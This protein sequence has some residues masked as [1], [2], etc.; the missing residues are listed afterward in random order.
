M[1]DKPS[2]SWLAAFVPSAARTHPLWPRIEPWLLRLGE[3]FLAQ[4]VQQVLMALGGFLLLRWMPVE[5]YAAFTLAFA[6]QSAMIAFV[7]VGFSGAI[8]PLVGVRVHDPA[9][10]GAYVAGARRLRLQLLPFVLAGGLVAFV[11]LGIRQHLEAAMIVGLFSLVSVTIWCNAISVLHGAPLV[12]RQEL[13]FLQAMQNVMGVVR[14]MIYALGHVTG[15]LGSIFALALNTVLN[16]AQAMAMSRRGRPTFDEPHG[17]SPATAAARREILLF[18]R[19]QVPVLVF[20]ALQG[21]IIVFLISVFG[22]GAALAA[23]G[24]LSRLNLMF[25]VVPYFLGWI[26]LPY[27]SRI[28]RKLVPRRFW[29]LTLAG[30]MVLALVPLTG[31]LWPALFLWLLGPNYTYLRLEV[32]LLL[33]ASA[34]GAGNALIATLSLAR[35]WVFDDAIIWIAGLGIGLQLAAAA[36]LDIGRPAGAIS[37]TIAGNFGIGLAY[38]ALA[39]RGRRRDIQLQERPAQA[40][41]RI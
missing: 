17:D 7:D 36:V 4:G 27:F 5:D 40:A 11:I 39:M 41:G 33:L 12:I 16:G 18:A 19:P 9:V 10:I 30:G 31:F 34:I 15:W 20:N 22:S 1:I 24:A 14:V 38:L 8:V 23:T 35:N 32:G 26:V 29:Q 28:D 25:S 3:F 21:Q 37:L 2:V 13:R 6:I